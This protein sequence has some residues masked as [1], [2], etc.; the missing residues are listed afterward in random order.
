MFLILNDLD[1]FW[2]YARSL[3]IDFVYFFN[4]I[5]F[6]LGQIAKREILPKIARVECRYRSIVEV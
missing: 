3:Y 5:H 1:I 6:L 4:F 2:Y